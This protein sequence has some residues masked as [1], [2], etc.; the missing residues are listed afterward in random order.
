VILHETP[1][2][3]I[4]EALGEFPSK[5]RLGWSFP[6]L[7]RRPGKRRWTAKIDAYRATSCM[8]RIEAIYEDPT[9][10]RTRIAPQP[11]V[12]GTNSTFSFSSPAGRTALGGTGASQITTTVGPY[13]YSRT[14]L[15][16]F[17]ICRTP[18]H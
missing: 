3:G 5:R 1:K 6:S 15:R 2:E 14:M 9:S 7:K 12:L 13:R 11:T 4:R 18:G 8:T 10:L 16:K 17:I